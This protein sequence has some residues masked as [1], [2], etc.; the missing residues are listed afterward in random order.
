YTG[1]DCILGR[2]RGLAMR[3]HTLRRSDDAAIH[4]RWNPALRPTLTIDAGDEVVFETRSGEDDQIRRGDTAADLA[5][6]DMRRLHA[7]SGPVYVTNAEPRDTLAG[8]ILHL[9]PAEWALTMQRPGVGLLT[10]VAGQ[11]VARLGV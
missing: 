7:L 2:L 3:V 10:D 11:R 1:A 5:R 8:H 9:Q 6:L 4:Y